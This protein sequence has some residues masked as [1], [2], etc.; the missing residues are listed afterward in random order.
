MIKATVQFDTP[1]GSEKQFLVYRDGQLVEASR[2]TRPA[3]ESSYDYQWTDTEASKGQHSYV[4]A[5]REVVITSPMWVTS[6]AEPQSA[7][8]VAFDAL[9]AVL[10]LNDPG[11]FGDRAVAFIDI[12]QNP[13]MNEGN[14]VYDRFGAFDGWGA[15]K[16]EHDARF[17][18]AVREAG[19]AVGGKWLPYRKETV[20]PDKVKITFEAFG[21]GWWVTLVQQ[22]GNWT[23]D[24]VEACSDVADESL[25]WTVR[26]VDG[27]WLAA[28]QAPPEPPEQVAFAVFREVLALEYPQWYKDRK[29]AFINTAQHSWMKQGNYAYDCFHEPD[30]KWGT[31]A[32]ERDPRFAEAIKAAGGVV[33]G[34]WFSTE[35]EYE[36]ADKGKVMFQA[37]NWMWWVNAVRR[38]GKWT[39]D[40]V[41]ADGE[42][43]EDQPPVRWKVRKTDQGWAVSR[44]R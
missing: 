2:Q 28:K 38:N 3:G 40:D 7:E 15:S 31:T 37:W 34:K 44:A 20:P 22:D 9:R 26:R 6:T 29:V 27:R 10:A 21:G 39:A 23:T 36:S 1:T 17:A 8:R 14:Y 35:T 11:E 25:E 5:V 16:L 33:G 12:G 30:A 4:L 42:G 19:G 43:N 13:W 32:L 41:Q 18:K 24:V